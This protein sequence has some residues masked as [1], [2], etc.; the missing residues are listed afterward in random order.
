MLNLRSITLEH[1]LYI[2]AF[3][4]AAGVRLLQ[5]G[6]A[7][8]SEF[9]ANWALQALQVS[10]GEITGIGPNPGYV[11]LTGLLFF[12]FGSSN[13]LARFW[14][15]LA[16]SL[17]ILLPFNFRQLLDRKVAIVL[18]FGLALDPGL[19]AL[20]RLAG[21]PML[22]MSFGLIALGF[23]F[24]RMPVLAGISLGLAFLG[25]TAII[26]GI[27]GLGL[28]WLLSRLWLR[29][30]SAEFPEENQLFPQVTEMRKPV[31]ISFS[32]T[33][34][35]L[36]SLFFKYP[37]GL[38]AF[39]GT[40]PEALNSWFSDSGIPASRV[41]LAPIIYQPLAIFFVLIGLVRVW[42]ERSI[43]LNWLIIWLFS[44]LI[45]AIVF[46]GRHV[47]DIGW[48]L[49]PLW[50]LAAFEIARHLKFVNFEKVPAVVQA[51]LLV[52]LLGLGWF[53][54]S[55]LS[56][57]TGD[58]QNIQLRLAVIGGTIGLSVVTTLMVALGWSTTVA[59]RGLAWGV[60]FSLTLYMMASMW[61]VSQLRK[62]GEQELW[63]PP[64][65]THQADLLLETLRDISGWHK[66]HRQEL[67]VFV[68]APGDSLRW[69]LRDWRGSIFLD[70][71]PPTE[72]P[73]AIITS[74][75]QPD[76]Q[77]GV[78][79][80]G[81][82]F[83]WL[84]SPGWDY[85]LP[86]NWALWL[87]FRNSPQIVERIILWVRTDLIPGGQLEFFGDDNLLFDLEPSFDTPEEILPEMEQVE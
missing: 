39:A 47:S 73:S 12:L 74:L 15:A 17:L 22:A 37:E 49:F 7:P 52:L 64:P 87:V 75:E 34:L 36:G 85:G 79:Y 20:S 60:G 14:P 1:G 26:H 44:A 50:T 48:A 67:D 83:P 42:R 41:F 70:G 33:L 61:G 71:L 58:M 23:F 5:L 16:G 21:G 30:R 81:Q 43:I 3:A 24:K 28:A 78:S 27:A 53:N 19:V 32:I 11:S 18:A 29:W 35:V 63:Y 45:I 6:A 69:L 82:D 56:L 65:V 86:Q 38:S 66:G 59:I 13:F 54:L 55:A 77:L 10:K 8:L 80:S 40:I 57:Q 4:L 72:L 2:L 76:L 25:G 62:N 68:I 31:L 51:S 46:P 84:V 9:E